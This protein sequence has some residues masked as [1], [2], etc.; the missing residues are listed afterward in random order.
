MNQSSYLISYDILSKLDINN[1][2]DV[3][4]V[5]KLIMLNQMGELF[6]VLICKKNINQISLKNLSRMTQL[7]CNG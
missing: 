4:S 1:V 2:D 7:N 3:T 5:K 6:K